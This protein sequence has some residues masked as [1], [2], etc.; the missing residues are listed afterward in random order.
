MPDTI[1]KLL[2]CYTVR[3]TNAVIIERLAAL[4]REVQTIKSHMQQGVVASTKDTKK[5]P[6]GLQIALH[7]IEEGKLS[8]PFI[9]TD[10][11]MAHLAKK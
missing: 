4:E 2:L 6:H 7:E 1:K 5:L 11:F 10:E 9:T 3:M 8:G